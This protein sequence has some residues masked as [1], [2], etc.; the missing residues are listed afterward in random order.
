MGGKADSL[1]ISFADIKNECRKWDFSKNNIIEILDEPFS[2]GRMYVDSFGCS[3]GLYNVDALSIKKSFKTKRTR[4]WEK[5]NFIDFANDL[6]KEIGL[7]L[8]TYGIDNFQYERVDQVEQNNMEFLRYRCMLEGYNLKISNGKAIIVS[9]KF[10]ESQ[11]S[12]LALDPSL[13]IGKYKFKCTSNHIYGGCEVSSFSKEF[14]K[15]SYI[16]NNSIGEVKKITDV[17]TSSLGETTR[18]A[19]NILR[20]FNKL[21]TT[22]S[23]TISKNTNIAAGNTILLENLSMF[24]GKYIIESVLHD[25]V[26]AKSFLTVRKVLEGY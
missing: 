18:F 23:F 26:N 19:K 22:G 3:N 12:V 2:T 6:I 4:T 16:L 8:E 14:I 11:N 13:F 5:V 24:N 7:N 9:E 17:N 20:S 21:E 1:A 25:L 10:L 15:G